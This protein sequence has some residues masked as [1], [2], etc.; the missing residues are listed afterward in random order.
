MKSSDFI[1]EGPTRGPGSRRKKKTTQSKPKGIPLDLAKERAKEMS[2]SSPQ[3][4]YVV[5]SKA[6][7]EE[8]FPVDG[9]SMANRRNSILANY[10]IVGSYNHNG[11]WRKE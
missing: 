10:E 3:G 5:R 7:P 8:H 11:V 9:F 4:T 1:T 6:N 2:Y